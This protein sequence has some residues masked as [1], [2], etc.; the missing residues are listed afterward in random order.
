MWARRD[1]SSLIIGIFQKMPGTCIDIRLNEN[2]N[3]KQ[4]EE[5]I[6]AIH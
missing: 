3:P 6:S 1:W 5:T 2:N 4:G